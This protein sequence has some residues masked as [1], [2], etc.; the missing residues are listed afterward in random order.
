M[1]YELQNKPSHEP[2]FL[3]H[4]KKHFK[5]KPEQITHENFGVVKQVYGG[6]GSRN[7]KGENVKIE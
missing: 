4:Q 1:I 6:L 2:I 5:G 3:S 7:F